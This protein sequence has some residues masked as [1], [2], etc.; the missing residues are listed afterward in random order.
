MYE[1]LIP[2]IQK[3]RPVRR[4]KARFRFRFFVREKGTPMARHTMEIFLFFFLCLSECFQLPSPFAVCAVSAYLF[5]EKRLLYPTIGMLCSLA[6]RLFWGADPD[7]WQYIGLG[8]LLLGKFYPPRAIWAASVYTACALSLR[9]FALIF[10]PTTQEAMILCTVSLMVGILCTPAI[11]HAVQLAEQHRGR[12]H[13]DDLLCAMVLGAVMLSGAGRVGIGIVNIGFIL[14][15]CVILLAAIIGGSM[16]AVCAGLVCGISLALCG[17]SDG[18]VVCFAFSGIVCGLFHGHKRGALA[19]VYLLCSLFASYAIRFQLDYPFIAAAVISSIL[20][21]L[22]PDRIITSVYTAVTLVSPDA[23]NNEAAYAQHMRAQWVGNLSALA[24]QL[25]E[26]RLPQ[27]GETE[28]LE[29]IVTRMC[30]GCDQLPKCWH[31]NA[32][33][34][35]A[36]MHAYFVKGDNASRMEDCPR[37]DAWPVLALENERMDQQRLLRYAY[38]KREREATRTHLT[39]IAQAMTRIS[40]EGGQCD[41][42]DDR[43]RGEAEFVMRRL[44][45][46]GR[47][48]YAL[49]V[50]RHIRIALRYEPTLTR[51]KQLQH[52]C[53]T[54]SHQLGI[55]LHIA[56]R[57]KDIILFEETPPMT[58]ECFHLSASSGD[59]NGINGDSVLTRTASGGMEIAMLSDGMGH[60]DQAHTESQETLELLSLCLDAGYTVPAAL[61]AINCIMLNA[62]DG[63]QYATVDLCVADLWQRTAT[64]DKLGACPSLLISGESL[65]VLE[66]SA[67]PLGILPEIETSSHVFAFGDGDMLIQF[68]DGLSDACG[69]VQALERQAELILRDKL[70]R[71][72]E[73]VCTALM[74]AAMRRSGGV[75]QDDI[76]VVCMLFKKRQA[77]RRERELPPEEYS[78]QY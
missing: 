67:L 78:A 14:S 47:I 53:E 74:S 39:A 77:K 41:S 76:T 4:R 35:R 73:A 8:V 7:I 15:G 45:I 42:D 40:R 66:S 37:R 75:P 25:P 70:H 32:D 9:L 36:C 34:T 55:P 31:E 50:S 10:M 16:G 61:D 22:I 58:V 26:V 29:D 23:A 52:F 19:V 56:Q 72:P 54:L 60:G 17:H 20:F 57:S 11:C 24:Q 3:S 63:E 49:R 12:L 13:V 64:L 33:Q 6:L 21:F 27:P 62:T 28:L 59:G 1:A 51:Q 68:T 30:D 65:R 48:L 5:C 46:S 71:S 38:A 18:Y 69:G 43:L 44:R 2:G